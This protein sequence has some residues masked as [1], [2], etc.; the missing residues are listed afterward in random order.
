MTDERWLKCNDVLWKVQLC[1]QAAG[2][3]LPPWNIFWWL[4]GGAYWLFLFAR[5]KGDERQDLRMAALTYFLLPG[6]LLMLLLLWPFMVVIR[7]RTNEIEQRLA[8]RKRA[9]LQ[10]PPEEEPLR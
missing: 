1:V 10:I 6:V 2:M 3:V 9:D 5:L 4:V 7:R 8:R